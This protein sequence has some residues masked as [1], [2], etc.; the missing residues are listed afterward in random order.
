LRAFTA[1]RWRD[2]LP[3]AAPPFVARRLTFLI[4]AGLLDAAERDLEWFKRRTAQ[5]SAFA[6]GMVTTQFQPFHASSAGALEFARGR[7]DAAVMLLEQALPAV[8]KGPPVVLSAGGS[9]GQY[10]AAT[11]AA[12][13]EAVGKVGEAVATLEQAV[14]DRVGVT[15]G[16]T[17]NR[18]MRTRAQLARLYRKSG[19]EDKARAVEAHL[20]KLLAAADG[21]HPLR[22]DL[23]RR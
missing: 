12:A 18:W 10:A 9:Q 15:L 6:P 20:L 2:P 7:P 3:D 4:E 19:H 1:A 21:D 5:A 11:L 14:D 16:N 13:L 17:P 8:R 23:S 22:L